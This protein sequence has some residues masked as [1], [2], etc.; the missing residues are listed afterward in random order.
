MFQS[1]VVIN[2]VRAWFGRAGFD[3]VNTCAQIDLEIRPN[4]MQKCKIVSQE[5]MRSR[6]H[7]VDLMPYL[8]TL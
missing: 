3:T 8:S 5:V 2:A 1:N 7:N 6:K 4:A